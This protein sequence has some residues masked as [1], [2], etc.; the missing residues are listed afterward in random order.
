MCETFATTAEN[1]LDTWMP[2]NSFKDLTATIPLYPPL[3]S[4]EESP[5]DLKT[6]GAG[7]DVKLRVR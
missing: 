6:A 1:L 3:G 2:I 4:Q 7:S 5:G